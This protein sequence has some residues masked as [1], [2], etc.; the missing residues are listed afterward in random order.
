MNVKWKRSGKRMYRFDG[1]EVMSI[2]F[3]AADPNT[4]MWAWGVWSSHHIKEGI[5]H[6]LSRAKKE[7]VEQIDA[8]TL[9]EKSAK[10]AE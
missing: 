8:M 1:D 3:G 4:T 5:T 6:S 10:G 2:I 9:A 7:A